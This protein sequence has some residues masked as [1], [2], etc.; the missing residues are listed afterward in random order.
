MVQ[1]SYYTLDHVRQK[2]TYERQ[3]ACEVDRRVS[4]RKKIAMTLT[5]RLDNDARVYS[6]KNNSSSTRRFCALPVAVALLAIGLAS[7][8]PVASMRDSFTLFFVR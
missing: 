1:K 4:S 5:G 6:F 7:P 2:T 8:Y 3:S